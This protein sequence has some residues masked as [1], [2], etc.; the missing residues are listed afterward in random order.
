MSE[1][2]FYALKMQKLI[3]RI[4]FVNQS[5]FFK[6]IFRF[7]HYVGHLSFLG[8]TS[9]GFSNRIMK[10]FSTHTIQV[11][12]LYRWCHSVHHMYSSPFAA[13]AQHLHPFELFFVAT[14]IT[15]VPWAF[16]TH[17]LTYWTWFLVS[18]SVSYEVSFFKGYEC[19]KMSFLCRRGQKINLKNSGMKN[20]DFS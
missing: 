19:L 5:N 7:F 18:Q 17:C 4:K 12:W 14:F 13:A 10:S 8:R 6:Q 11:R 16:P 2:D 9:F 15:T 20:P 3:F 1:M